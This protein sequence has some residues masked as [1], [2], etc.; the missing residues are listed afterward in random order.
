MSVVISEEI[1]KNEWEGFLLGLSRP[2]F[3]QSWNM[4]AV[5]EALGEETLTIVVREGDSIIG[6]ALVAV[7]RARRGHYLYL[8]YGPVM[9]DAGWKHFDELTAYLVKRGKELDVDFIRSSPF[10]EDTDD[11]KSLYAG[12]GW[13]RA[14][15]HMLAEHIWWL[16][17]SGT[18]EE[19]QKGMRKTMR[20]LIRKAGKEGVTIRQSTDLKDV[21]RFIQIHKDTVTRH[22][23]V[24]YSNKLFTTQ[25]ESFT[26]D[27]E[28]VVYTAE[29]EGKE[30]SSGI[31]MYYGDMASYHHGASLSEYNRIPASYVLQWTAIQEAKKRGCTTYNFW[32][33]VPEHKFYSKVLH[34]PHPFIGVTKFKTGFGGELYNLLPCQDLP[35]TTKYRFFTRPIEVARRIKRG[36]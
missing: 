4:R 31:M 32:G 3:L 16:D 27:D 11:N 23:F 12:N 14:P 19:T 34:R 25:V 18:E 15:I 36:F 2:P 29:Y 13:K 26:E 28:V 30:I 8:P 9:S 10:I 5:H 21:E 24:P 6:V 1:S 33:I 17:I 7:V 22:N 20:N 35:L